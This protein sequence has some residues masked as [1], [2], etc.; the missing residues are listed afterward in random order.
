MF[1][2]K[3]K[4]LF[5][6][7]LASVLAVGCNLST[8]PAM[9]QAVET[10]TENRRPLVIVRFNQPRVYFEQSLSNATQR[11]LEIKRDVMFELVQ[12][13]P[14]GAA[15]KTAQQNLARVVTV[16]RD[17]GVPDSNIRIRRAT[18]EEVASDEVHVFVQ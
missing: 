2:Q 16:L 17:T 5:T 10:G 7:L 8:R 11:A 4:T 14:P 18:S 1:R 3:K 15:Q 9:A 13:V 12:L 6:I